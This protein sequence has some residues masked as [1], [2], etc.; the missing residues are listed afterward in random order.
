MVTASV[1][2]AFQVLIE[3]G[4]DDVEQGLE[5]LNRQVLRVAKDK[6]HMTMAV[7]VLEESTGQWVIYSAGAPPVL[8]LGQ[9]GKHRVLFCAGSPLGTRTG[10]ELGRIEGKLEKSDRLLMY[11]DGIPESA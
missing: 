7:L 10:F 5:L 3:N 6:Y 4:L 9:N 8:S 1:A 2:T 11:T